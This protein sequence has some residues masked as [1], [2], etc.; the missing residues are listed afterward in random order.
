MHVIVPPARHAGWQQPWRSQTTTNTSPA[1][2]AV[3]LNMS[4]PE[5][6]TK[7]LCATCGSRFFDLSHDPIR[8]PKCDAT[9]QLP[10]PAPPKRMFRT[11]A[12]LEAELVPPIQSGSS[13]DVPEIDDDDVSPPPEEEPERG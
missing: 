13:E 7:R 3:I 6:G 9:F 4:K 2:Q 12:P 11:V 5:L 1:V 10:L 8:C